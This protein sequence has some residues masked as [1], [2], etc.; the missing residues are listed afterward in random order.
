MN[1]HELVSTLD[2]PTYHQDGRKSLAELYSA[3][4][5]LVDA[6]WTA[7]LVTTQ[8]L[9]LGE[10]EPIQLP[11][12]AFISRPELLISTLSFWVLSGVHGEESA[13]PN[14]LAEEM[15]TL[16][17][18]A[19]QGIPF[20]VLPMLNPAGYIRDWRYENARRDSIVG[21]SVTDCE[22]LLHD[23]P[24]RQA[25]FPVAERSATAQAVTQW[26]ANYQQHFIPQLVFDHHEDEFEENPQ[27][28]D[29][30]QFNSYIYYYGQPR[31]VGLAEKVIEILLEN[32]MPISTEG[33]TRFGEQIQRG[34]V[35]A[36]PDGSVD[37]FFA[38]P[39]YIENDQ[40]KTKPA[41]E[42]VIV[43]ETTRKP[44]GTIALPQRVAAHRQIIQHYQQFWQ[45]V[46]QD[47][48]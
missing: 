14:A 40:R 3:Y 28:D 45:Q 13:G 7:E 34:V 9:H 38:S 42:A 22:P 25:L 18:F 26:I 24:S 47:Q 35:A 11:I 46:D 4:A 43:V 27:V 21:Q 1:I 31:F 44:D 12:F 5:Q 37:E 10:G 20:V 39:E 41:A 36:S 32:G 15:Q 16:I 23:L 17:E 30:Q 33:K 29:P 48:K 8:E 6:G 19:R 2:V